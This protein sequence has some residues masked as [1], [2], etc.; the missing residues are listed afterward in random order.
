MPSSYDVIV[1]GAG[2]MGAATA[3]ALAQRGKK[4]L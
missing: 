3:W 2:A 1:V 4:V